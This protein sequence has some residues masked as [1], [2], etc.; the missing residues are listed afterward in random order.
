MRA[1]AERH[2]PVH[3]FVL[4]A[5]RQESTGLFVAHRIVVGRVGA[6]E[7]PRARLEV[8]AVVIEVF[9]GDARDRADGRDVAHRLLHRERH[10]RGISAQRLEHVGPLEQREQRARDLPVRRVVRADH[11]VHGHV[12]H[13]GVG[14]PLAV[15]LGLE[16]AR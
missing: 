11:E 6:E 1:H 16:Q 2:Q 3:V 9:E 14:E 13:L 7:E 5:F 15:L 8:Q 10:E 4:E 12:G